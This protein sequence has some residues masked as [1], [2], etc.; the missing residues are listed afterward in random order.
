MTVEGAVTIDPND[1][2]SRVDRQ[3]S[4]KRGSRYVDLCEFLRVA[5]VAWTAARTLLPKLVT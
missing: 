5:R 1:V 4:R 3:R 2:A